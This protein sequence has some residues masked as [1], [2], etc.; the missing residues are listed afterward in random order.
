MIGIP[1]REMAKS[2]LIRR[3]QLSRK[4]RRVERKRKA[5]RVERKR[6]AREKKEEKTRFVCLLLPSNY[7]FF[8]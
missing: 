8:F 3:R 6:K 7:S 1:K 4:A 5:R 2:P